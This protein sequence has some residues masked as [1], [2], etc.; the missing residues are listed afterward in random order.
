MDGELFAKESYKKGGQTVTSK[1]KIGDNLL[2]KRVFGIGHQ[3]HLRSEAPESIA[4][5]TTVFPWQL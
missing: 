2:R 4:Q 5:P 1:D 3:L